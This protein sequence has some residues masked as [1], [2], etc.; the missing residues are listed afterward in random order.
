MEGGNVLSVG[1]S[2][3]FNG[4]RITV[5]GVYAAIQRWC[6][7]NKALI[8]RADVVVIERQFCD[9]KATLWRA[10][11]SSRRSFKRTPTVRASWCTP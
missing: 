10:C 7:D 9:A 1:R 11:S 4:E 8:D 5:T 3:I 2:D 6:H